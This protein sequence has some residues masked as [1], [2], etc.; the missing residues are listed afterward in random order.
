MRNTTDKKLGA[1]LCAVIAVAVL[2]AYLALLFYGLLQE[3]GLVQAGRQ[4]IL[5]VAAGIGFIAV[6]G[7]LL[8]AM[9]AGVLIALFLRFREL[10]GGEE[11][12]AKKY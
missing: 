12:D 7:L 3:A 5:G 6:C 9:I 4:G 1:F 10:E 2:S 8:A 11:E